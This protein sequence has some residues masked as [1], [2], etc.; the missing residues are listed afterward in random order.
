[1]MH[2]VQCCRA[3]KHAFMKDDCICPLQWCCC[4]PEFTRLYLIRHVS[5]VD[6]LSAFIAAGREKSTLILIHHTTATA[7][8]EPD[9]MTAI[10]GGE[11]A[12]SLPVPHADG[13]DMTQTPLMGGPLLP[14]KVSATRRPPLVTHKATGDA[15]TQTRTTNVLT[16]PP[17]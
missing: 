5:I 14:T 7:R 8:V 6:C 12:P 9:P 3:F 13:S 10:Q 2:L 4:A 16:T 11:E 1:M 15:T 17:V